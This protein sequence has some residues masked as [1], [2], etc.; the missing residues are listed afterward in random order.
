MGSNRVMSLPA[1]NGGKNLPWKI[2][3]NKAAF[4]PTCS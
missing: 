3:S 4:S 2:N 1:A